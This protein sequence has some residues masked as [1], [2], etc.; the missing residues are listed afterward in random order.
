MTDYAQNLQKIVVPRARRA[1]P[2]A[3]LTPEEVTT[4]RATNGALQWLAGQGM[5]AIAFEVSRS[6]GALAAPKVSDLLELNHIIGKANEY[7]ED[8]LL[9][10]G[11]DLSTCCVLCVSDA[12]FANMPGGTSQSGA[13]I[14]L[15]D[16][17]LA[18]GQPGRFL[19]LEWKS[20]RQKRACRSTFGAEA[21]ALSDAADVGDFL[22]GLLYEIQ[23]PG[24]D[25]RESETRGVRMC[26]ATDC[27]DL[28][29]K[30]TKDGLSSSA[31][32]RLALE[33]VILKELLDRPSC[34]VYWVATDQ[35]LV[36]ILT[37][38]SAPPNYLRERLRE[39][40]WSLTELAGVAQKARP[41]RTSR[42]EPAADK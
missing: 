7:A 5:P 6:Q 41:T 9:F 17:S 15:G 13:F 20:C 21:L 2:D 8:S 38:A 30:L 26:W 16:S 36:D 24:A 32:K 4:L 11:F 12:S 39:G 23:H 34:K 22:R 31:E 19:A 10:P 35:M 1:T 28:F 18:D 3:P 42:V 29:D 27:R 14:G 40:R 25:P 33:L 37:K